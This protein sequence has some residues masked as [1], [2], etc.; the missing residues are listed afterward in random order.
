MLCLT[1]HKPFWKF[2]VE[3][4][5]H[6]RYMMTTEGDNQRRNHWNSRIK[7]VIKMSNSSWKDQLIT[8]GRFS[9]TENVIRYV[10]MD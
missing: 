8:Q 5:G 9:I 4:G 6:R 3:T 2:R 10:G 7:R 1:N